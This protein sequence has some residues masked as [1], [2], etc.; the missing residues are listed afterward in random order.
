M[1]DDERIKK[2]VIDQ[3]YWDGR[4]NAADIKVKVVGGNVTLEGTV[5][6]LRNVMAA[7]DD[8]MVIPEVVSIQNNLEVVYPEPEMPSDSQLSAD[9]MDILQWDP[10]I[11]EE[12]IEVIVDNGIVT[13]KGSVDAYWKKNLVEDH[14]MDL[15]GVISLDN[16]LTVVPT[17]KQSDEDIASEIM[18][19]LERNS[20]IDER[21]VD[22]KVSDGIVALEGTVP[23]LSARNEATNAALYTPGVV[24]YNNSNLIVSAAA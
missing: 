6:S 19:A 9:I 1:T 21:E 24:G 20:M 7:H 8:V 18:K 14:V 10:D 2:Q 15:Y 13:L 4:V 11:N 16:K 17:E 5:P 22:V 12:K 3:L 23:N